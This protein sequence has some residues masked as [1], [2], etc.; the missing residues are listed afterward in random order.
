[1]YNYTVKKGFMAF[2]FGDTPLYSIG[3]ESEA[4]KKE[5]EYKC[6]I[7]KEQK[8]MVVSLSDVE[9]LI[10]KYGEDKVIRKIK[11]KNVYIVPV[12]EVLG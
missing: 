4:L 3:I 5:G 6:I 9:R 11:G 1:M 7:G 8:E 10:L 2:Q 12:K